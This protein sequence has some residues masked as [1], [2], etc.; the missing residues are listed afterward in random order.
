MVVDRGGSSVKIRHPGVATRPRLWFEGPRTARRVIRDYAFRLYFRAQR[1]SWWQRLR[2]APMLF[3]VECLVYRVDAAAE[4]AKDLDLHAARDND[5]DAVDG[6]KATFDAYKARFESLLRRAH[7]HNEAVAR[8]LDLGERYVYLENKVTSRGAASR[9]EALQLAE[10]RPTDVRLLHSMTY[11]LLHRPVDNDLLDLLWPVEVLADIG[12]DL[13][14]YQQDIA[15]GRYNTYDAFVRLYGHAAPHRLRAEIDR[16]EQ[17]FHTTLARF[18]A[19]R[20]AE[21]AALCTRRYRSLTEV[22]P[23]PLLHHGS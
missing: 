16:Y 13:V 19:N 14:D 21:L 7:A 8:Q 9:A 3:L 6:Y 15:A 4:R 22:L 20:Q 1:L 18:P 23:E 2:C 5:R 12:E 11:A 17:L 10:L